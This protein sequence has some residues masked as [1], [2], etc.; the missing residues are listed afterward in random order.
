MLKIDLIN[1][2]SILKRLALLQFVLFL[3]LILIS[4]KLIANIIYIYEE[5]FFRNIIVGLIGLFI[6]IIFHELIHGIFFKIF[7]PNGKV[8]YGYKKGMF[9]A[10]MP[11]TI[12]NR[13]QFYIILLAP[14]VI[15]SLLLFIA[16]IW[17]QVTSIIYIFAFH[18]AACIGDF[19]MAQMVYSNKHMKFIE[20]TEVGINLYTDKP[21]GITTS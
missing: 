12:F 7:N 17:M 20:D 3:S 1:N 8:K 14:F 2:I 18:G 19:Y 13:K 6:S 21:N 11:E 5:G 9:Y 16:L 10:S 4:F 15:I